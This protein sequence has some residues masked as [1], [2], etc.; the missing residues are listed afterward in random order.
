M[1]FK[2]FS[3]LNDPNW[4]GVI[5]QDSTAYIVIRVGYSF[6]VAV[7]LLSLL[8]TLYHHLSVPRF[9]WKNKW[10]QLWGWCIP[11]VPQRN[12]FTA[13][14]L[15]IDRWPEIC[16]TWQ[17]YWAGSDSC[18]KSHKCMPKSN[19]RPTSSNC[20]KMDS[21]VEGTPAVYRHVMTCLAIPCSVWCLGSSFYKALKITFGICYTP[22]S[23]DMYFK[24]A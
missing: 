5:E 1:I 18:S 15:C 12:F 2:V 21:G 4:L 11:M 14:T 22:R 3:K 24:E 16:L 23:L 7:T 13:T 17:V 8:L 9:S 6:S 10:V 19:P 20:K